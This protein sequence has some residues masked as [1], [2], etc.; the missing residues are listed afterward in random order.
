[1][2]EPLTISQPE[3]IVLPLRHPLRIFSGIAPPPALLAAMARHST[4]GSKLSVN[5][6]LRPN[7]ASWHAETPLTPSYVTTPPQLGEHVPSTSS[8][9][10][11]DSAPPSYEDAMAEDVGP[12]D[13][14]RRDY[15]TPNV[16]PE[17]R[18]EHQKLGFGSRRDSERLFPDSEPGDA[19]PGSFRGT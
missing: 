18:S 8:E 1:M 15:S 9:F 12:V 7:Q 16:L 13:G 6:S 14:H 19:P 2:L 11:A 4:P 17:A 10:E 3:F 5:T